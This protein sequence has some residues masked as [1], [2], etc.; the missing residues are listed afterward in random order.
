MIDRKHIE[1]FLHLNGLS[2]DSPEEEIRSLLISA[3]W[4]HEEVEAALVVLREDSN[5]HRQRVDSVHKV[6]GSDQKISPETLSSLLGMDV[7]IDSIAEEH[8][9]TLRRRYQ[10]QLLSIVLL[11]VLS[12]IVLLIALMWFLEVGIFHEYAVDFRL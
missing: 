1:Q 7:K 10:S 4:H 8:Q 9:N 3:R 11:S 5:T 6:F 2:S 12:A